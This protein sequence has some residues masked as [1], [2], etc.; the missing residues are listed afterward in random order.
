MLFR[1]RLYLYYVF[2]CYFPQVLTEKFHSLILFSFSFP[3]CK[4]KYLLKMIMTIKP[5]AQNSHLTIYGYIEVT[6]NTTGLVVRVELTIWFCSLR[7]GPT[8]RC[9]TY[10][11]SPSGS[12]TWLPE[13]STSCTTPRTPRWRAWPAWQTR[14]SPVWSLSL[15]SSFSP[16]RSQYCHS[17]AD[18]FL[19][20]H[21][22]DNTL[23][24][25]FPHSS[26]WPIWSVV[27]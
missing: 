7:P 4:T 13:W 6:I 1:L 23:T 9:W 16:G 20:I 24:C 21:W 5:S 8:T 2:S 15:S 3:N 27:A 18:R 17:L 22:R 12:T 10:L 11:W 26:L 14:L 25:F 19:L